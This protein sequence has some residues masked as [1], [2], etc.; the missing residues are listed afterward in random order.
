MKKWAPEELAKFLNGTLEEISVPT[1]SLSLNQI[2][3]LE[4]SDAHSISF[5][6]KE[7]ANQR[8]YSSSAALII[9]SD[10][11]EFD[12]EA[13]PKCGF[14]LR[15]QD[16]I[17]AVESLL[18]EWDNTPESLQHISSFAKIHP[19]AV[20]EGS[21]GD[22]SEIGPFCFVHLNAV[23]G[24]GVTLDANVSVYSNVEIADFTHVESGAVIGSPGFGIHRE[25]GKPRRIKH[26][27]GVQIGEHCT[28]GANSVVA[29]GFVEPTVLGNHVHLDSFVQI[30]HNAQI[31]DN[32]IFCSQSGVGGSTVMGNGCVVAGGA[33]IADNL[34]IGKNVTIAAKAGVTRD[35]PN[36][37]VVGGFPAVDIK[38]WRKEIISRR[39]NL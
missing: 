26:F 33:Q 37:C 22:D 6:K 9:V 8:F 24:Q 25:E 13:Q 3:S 20:V 18:E 36:N 16:V 27:G 1:D 32:A 34:K 2:H 39:K 29:A 14:I 12:P 23:I 28:V 19:T 7:K 30:G 10:L 11:F 38:E 35:L 5:F 17:V 21:V 15:V 4:N 31:G